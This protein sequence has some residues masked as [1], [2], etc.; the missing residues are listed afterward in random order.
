MNHRE[1]FELSKTWPHCSMLL[2]IKCFLDCVLC[3]MIALFF[4]FS[5]WTP[6]EPNSYEG[7]NEDC[8]ELKSHDMINSWN[9]KPCEG[10]NFWICEKMIVI[11]QHI[12]P[13]KA[14]TDFMFN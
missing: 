6:G 5:Y 14:E 10:Q 9:D 2:A 1:H 8:V 3:L 4:G 7:Q 13:W 12:Q 11:T